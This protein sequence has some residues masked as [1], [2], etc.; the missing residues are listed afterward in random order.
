[1]N[2]EFDMSGKVAL[3]TGASSGFGVHFA[4][5]LAER[6]AK[7]VVAARRVDRLEALVTEIQ[8]GGGEALAVAMDVTNADSIVAGFNQAEA[9]FGTVTVVSN[10][11]GIAETKSALKTDEAS[12]DR[13]MDTNSKRRLGRGE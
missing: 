13:V 7:V 12:W 10:N 4:K 9:A 5:I 6:G 3:V 11:A 1:M 2:T 8:A